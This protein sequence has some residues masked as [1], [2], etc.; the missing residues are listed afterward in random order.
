V[1]KT[2]E[3]RPRFTEKNYKR[4]FHHGRGTVKSTAN[5]HANETRKGK[6]REKVDEIVGEEADKYYRG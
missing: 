6:R 5:R 2:G 3:Q 4:A 1:L